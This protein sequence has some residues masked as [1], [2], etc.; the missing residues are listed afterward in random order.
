MIAAGL[1]VA[2]VGAAGVEVFHARFGQIGGSHTDVAG[3]PTGQITS[4]FISGRPDAHVAYPDATVMKTI[5]HPEGPT[6]NSLDGSSSDPAYVE[7]FMAT[8]D[9][10]AAVRDW[11][12][13]ELAAQHFT[14]YGAVGATY[15]YTEDGYV[16][17]DREVLIIGYIKPIQVRGILG[18]EVPASR[19]IF[20]TDYIINAV[21]DAFQRSRL[22]GDCYL[23]LP[24]PTASATSPNP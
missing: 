17:G 12:R 19:T 1:I 11:Y 8:P 7:V 23:T 6:R 4:D 15:M 21:A 18:L 5:V 10:A 22:P 9:S 24:T 14:C 13:N 3:L 16:R 20:E 2:A